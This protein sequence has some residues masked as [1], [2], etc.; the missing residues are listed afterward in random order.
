VVKNPSS[1][2][3]SSPRRIS[4]V[5]ASLP[6]SITVSSPVGQRYGDVVV[7]KVNKSANTTEVETVFVNGSAYVYLRFQAPG[8]YE[9]AAEYL[10]NEF[11][12][13]SRSNVVVVTVERSVLGIPIF[14]L[15][16]YLGS[17][18]AG[19]AAAAVVRWFFR[20]SV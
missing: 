4:T 20:K 17:L 2:E 18:G 1:V 10:G 9:I 13:P 12:M 19:I 7:Y 14:L 8:V 15:S 16:I 11:N 3:I 5:D 6:I